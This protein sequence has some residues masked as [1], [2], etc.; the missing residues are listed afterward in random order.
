M[1]NRLTV[2][3]ISAGLLLY[4]GSRAEQSGSVSKDQ[5]ARGRYL[6]DAGGCDDCH[7]P[8]VMSPKGPAP[9]M[10]RRLSGAP[11]GTRVPAVPAGLLS[12]TGWGALTTGDLTIWAGPWGVSFA[13]NLT[14]DK[15]TGMG[16]WTE[17]AFVKSMRT[18][19]HKGA[20]R[21]ILPPMPWQ[22]V[23]KLNDDDLK[24]M[25][26]YMQSLKP[27]ANKVPDPVLPK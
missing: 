4:T 8:K 19:K 14:P 26:A 17:A 21:D 20:L 18:G 10:S 23:G 13:A 1:K 24:A 9:D 11:A 2:L 22:S 7:T 25:F 12:T 3:V 6:V 16:T 27:V 15:T 5:V